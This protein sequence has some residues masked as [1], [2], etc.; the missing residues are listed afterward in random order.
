MRRLRYYL[1]NLDLHKDSNNFA[2]NEYREVVNL[3]SLAVYKGSNAKGSSD[4]A[5]K[6]NKAVNESSIN[7]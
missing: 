6:E 2:P 1:L 3:S 7:I 5:T 4:N